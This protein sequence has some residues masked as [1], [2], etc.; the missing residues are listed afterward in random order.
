[1]IYTCTDRGGP[2]PKLGPGHSASAYTSAPA[3]LISTNFLN[4]QSRGSIPL[5]WIPLTVHEET[6]LGCPRMIGFRIPFLR[7]FGNSHDIHMHVEVIPPR[8]GHTMSYHVP[9]G[10]QC[11]I[12]LRDRFTYSFHELLK[13]RQTVSIL[14]CKQ[15]GENTTKTHMYVHIIAV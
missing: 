11:C 15:L 13:G 4:I 12:I 14:S 7:D 5:F 1:M 9:L 6:T 2:A 10:E 3:A 8:S